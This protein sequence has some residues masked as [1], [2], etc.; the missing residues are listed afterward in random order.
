MKRAA[1]KL[2][3]APASVVLFGS[4]ATGEARA[5]SDIDVL[6]VRPSGDTD[7]DAWTTSLMRW[8]SRIV[9]AYAAKE[10]AVKSATRLVEIARRLII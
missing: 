2:R 5:G 8:V 10:S 4:A 7:E 9:R 1:A 3:P 6:I